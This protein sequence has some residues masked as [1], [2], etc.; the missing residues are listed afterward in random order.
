MPRL[1]WSAWQGTLKDSS[2]LFQ[3]NL[4]VRREHT[5]KVP[6]PLRIKRVGFVMSAVCPVNSILQ[7]FPDPVSTS[8]L[9]HTQTLDPSHSIP[10]EPALSVCRGRSR[11]RSGLPPR[12]SIG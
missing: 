3:S 11:P 8:H 4:G 6:S 10:R 5:L 12:G 7:T 2:P 1:D 9:G